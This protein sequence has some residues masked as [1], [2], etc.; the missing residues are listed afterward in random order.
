MTEPVTKVFTERSAVRPTKTPPRWISVFD[1][2]R[3]LGFVI[4]IA[5]KKFLAKATGG[6]KLGRFQTLA[7]AYAA[8]GE[9]DAVFVWRSR[10]AALR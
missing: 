6:H 1:N 9:F 10:L 3:L 2:D 5:D 7:K 8:I 4:E